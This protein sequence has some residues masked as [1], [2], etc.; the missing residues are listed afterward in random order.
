MSF[1]AVLR[2]ATAAVADD[3]PLRIRNLAPASGIYGEPVALGGDVLSSGYEL[4]FDSELANNFTSAASGGTLAFF[5]GE[6]AYL[7][8]GFRQAIGQRFEWGIE[9]PWVVHDGGYLDHTI[10]DF[11]S[12]FGFP[13]NGRR[14]AK[15]NKIDYFVADQ[16][17]VYV[18][19]QD[20]K[21]GIGDVRVTGGFQLLRDAARSL[22]VRALVKLPTGD[23]DSLTGSGATD[24]ATW[25]DYTDRELLA[26]FRLSMTAAAGF[27]VLGDGDLL[28]HKQNRVAGWGHLGLSYSLTDDWAVKAQLD[29]QGQLIDASVDQLGGEA[30]QGTFGVSWQ[31]TPRFWS[32]LAMVEDLTADSTSDVVLQLLIGTRF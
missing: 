24:F 10:Q 31:A 29:Y 12:I 15:L 30:L 28:P 7:T 16:N 11:H 13:N 5:D 18:D 23:V 1:V 17:K 22:A 8:Y 25:L 32:D 6:T 14:E 27:T 2:F 26:R 4:T 20:Q 19:F 9:L 21:D 3:A